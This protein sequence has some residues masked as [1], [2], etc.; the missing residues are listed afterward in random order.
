MKRIAQAILYKAVLLIGLVL[1]GFTAS[2]DNLG[3]QV[4]S[5]QKYLVVTMVLGAI[6][7]VFFLFLWFLERKVRR[8]ESNEHSSH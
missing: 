5:S 1:P 7:I 8:L 4:R 2:A 6:F 3:D